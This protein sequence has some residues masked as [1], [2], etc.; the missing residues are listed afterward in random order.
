MY[1]LQL[2]HS[3]YNNICYLPSN[4]ELQQSLEQFEEHPAIK[5]QHSSTVPS[6]LLIAL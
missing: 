3:Y 6:G 1:Q 2:H 4:P 5:P